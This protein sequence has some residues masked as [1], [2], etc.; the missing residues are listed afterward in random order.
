M[1]IFVLAQVLRTMALAAVGLSV[2][3]WVGLMS[4]RIAQILSGEIA[5]DWFTRKS[6]LIAASWIYRVGAASFALMALSYHLTTQPDLVF[7]FAACSALLAWWAWTKYKQIDKES[8][9]LTRMEQLEYDR[10]NNADSDDSW[11]P[12]VS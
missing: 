8:L 11:K 3:A 7:A 5:Q 10:T 6:A 12:T 9:R 1:D 2:F 4:L